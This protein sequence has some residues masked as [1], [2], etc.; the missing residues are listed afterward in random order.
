MIDEATFTAV[1]TVSAQCSY[2]VLIRRGAAVA[3][4]VYAAASGTEAVRL[5]RQELEMAERWISAI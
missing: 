2:K 3:A 5:A 4:F 1:R